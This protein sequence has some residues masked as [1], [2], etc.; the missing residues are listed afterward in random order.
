MKYYVVTA[1]NKSHLGY[2]FTVES[3]HERKE[4]VIPSLTKLMLSFF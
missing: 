4:D 1:K 3:F 2:F